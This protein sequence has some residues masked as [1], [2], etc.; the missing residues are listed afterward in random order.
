[1]AVIKRIFKQGIKS[2]L[3]YSSHFWG[4]CQDLKVNYT[5]ALVHATVLLVQRAAACL[6][7]LFLLRWVGWGGRNNPNIKEAPTKIKRGLSLN[8]HDNFQWLNKK[9][10]NGE[11]KF[12]NVSTIKQIH[13]FSCYTKFYFCWNCW[14]A[15][16]EVLLR[17]AAL[18]LS[19]EKACAHPDGS[20]EMRALPPML[21]I[22]GHL[23]L[24]TTSGSFKGINCFSTVGKYKQPFTSS[25]WLNIQ[26]LREHRATT[27]WAATALVSV[28]HFTLSR[29]I[30][31]GFLRLH[32]ALAL[33]CVEAFSHLIIVA[34]SLHY[35]FSPWVHVFHTGSV[36]WH[37]D[38]I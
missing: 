28:Q 8:A 34:R 12:F 35:L 18:P 27:R 20:R 26:T 10:G 13:I 22:N 21:P 3:P 17:R 15:Q 23:D 19:G 7:M 11:M 9:N 5:V 2:E 36:C 25:I 37:K 30:Q 33:T 29:W 16:E 38:N 4:K 31:H 24:L 14:K 32:E 1:M 6:I